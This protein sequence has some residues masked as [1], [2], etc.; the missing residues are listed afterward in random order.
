MIVM[1]YDVERYLTNARNQQVIGSVTL[2][3]LLGGYPRPGMIKPK[4]PYCNA[5]AKGSHQTATVLCDNWSVVHR[6]N[7]LLVT[8]LRQISLD[9]TSDISYPYINHR[10]PI[11][12]NRYPKYLHFFSVVRLLEHTLHNFADRFKSIIKYIQTDNWVTSL[13]Y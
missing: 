4:N 1:W 9:V 13:Y 7:G 8:G 3:S 12:W 2:R 6:A 11:R 10:N 5:L